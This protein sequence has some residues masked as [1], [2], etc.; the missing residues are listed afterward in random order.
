VL[1][2]AGAKAGELQLLSIAGAAEG[3]PFVVLG[4]DVRDTAY[5]DALGF[6]T[7]LAVDTAMTTLTL[8][9][10]STVELNDSL[11][12]VGVARHLSMLDMGRTL[13]GRPVDPSGPAAAAPLGGYTVGDCR[14]DGG[15]DVFD[16]LEAALISVGLRPSPSDPGDFRVCDV[17]LDGAIDALDVLDIA[18]PS[19]GNQPPSGATTGVR[20]RSV[21]AGSEHSCALV[22][23]GRPYCWG[24]NRGGTLASGDT[25]DHPTPVPVVGDHR[26]VQIAAGSGM[27]CGLDATGAAYCWERTGSSPPPPPPVPTRVGNGLTFVQVAIG[28]SSACVIDT[29]GSGYCWGN[30]S[31]GKLGDGTTTD[32]AGPTAVVGG[33]IFVQIDVLADQA[34]GVTDSGGV[35]CW[36]RGRYG[37]LG[38]GGFA[39]SPV[40]VEV[41]GDRVF[42]AVGVGP[43]RACGLDVDGRAWCWGM[44]A[45]GALGNGANPIETCTTSGGTTFPCSSTPVPV[46]TSLR[47]VTIRAGGGVTCGLTAEGEAYCWG[48]NQ[49]GTGGVG[50]T[51]TLFVPTPVS[52]GLRFSELTNHSPHVCGRTTDADLYCWGLNSGGQLGDGT[53]AD[54]S[55]PVRVLFPA[56]P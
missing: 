48:S 41:V 8:E 21:A 24:D 3:S 31:Y 4:F 30:N 10:V 14:R 13:L 45:N 9:S 33:L 23:S 29:N 16:A 32:R 27:T 22:A 6:R 19:V 39:D 49:H 46:D 7:R 1:D 44:G 47:F 28:T 56:I 20:Y 12:A 34:C 43:W 36:G 54:R 40:P 50:T 17:V 42:R 35:W 55:L 51:E 38:N 52:G 5:L 25:V 53:T 18:S 11:T 2:T 15:I 37:G 26:F